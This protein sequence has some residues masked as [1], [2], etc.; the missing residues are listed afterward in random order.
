MLVC[1]SSKKYLC[2]FFINNFNWIYNI[3]EEMFLY[4]IKF[5]VVI[6]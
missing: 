3:S 5:N 4:L 1:N 6:S 2:G